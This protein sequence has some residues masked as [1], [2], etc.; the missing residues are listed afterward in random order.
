MRL[1]LT[2]MLLAMLRLK[3]RLVAMSEVDLKL[4][5]NLS[6]QLREIL[7]SGAIPWV[8]MR[9][10]LAVSDC[11]LVCVSLRVDACRGQFW[12]VRMGCQL[13]V[14]HMVGVMVRLAERRQ[15]PGGGSNGYLTDR[16]WD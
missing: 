15:L 11:R 6:I 7:V 1:M 8:T 13:R 14:I 10:R 5:V 4:L 3:R 2:V 12:S 16:S 9:P